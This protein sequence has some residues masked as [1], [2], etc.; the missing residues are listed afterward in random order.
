MNRIAIGPEGRLSLGGVKFCDNPPGEGITAVVNSL[1]INQCEND[2]KMRF[3]RL[4]S[5]NCDSIEIHE[6]SEIT[7]QTYGIIS[8]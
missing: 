6:Y 4:Y 2:L 5:D 8:R 3:Q 1:T 7:L